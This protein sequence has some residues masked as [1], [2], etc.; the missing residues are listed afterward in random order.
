MSRDEH[1]HTHTH[2][3]TRTDTHETI[4]DTRIRTPVPRHTR[5]PAVSHKALT[6]AVGLSYLVG[7]SLLGHVGRS[8][9][10]V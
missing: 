10:F 3:H 4:C 1:T 2:T 6:R 5:A 7:R 8:A 9:T